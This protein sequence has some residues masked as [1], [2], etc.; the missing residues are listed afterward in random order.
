MNPQELAVLLTP[1]ARGWI[2][3]HRDAQPFALALR[4]APAGLPA[5]LL[6]GQIA[7]LQKAAAKLPSWARNGCIL[8]ARAYEQ[9]TSEALAEAKPWGNGQLALDLSCGLGSDDRALA[10]RFT[11][12]VALEPD[13]L[14]AAVVRDNQG[15]MAIDNVTLL[16]QR[17]EDFVAS[18]DGPQADLIYIDPD[19]RDADG[20]RQ[21][22]LRDCQP[23][24]LALLPRLKAIGK[25][26]LIKASPMLDLQAVEAELAE[27]ATLWVAAEGNECKE[28][29]IEIDTEQPRAARGAI[30]L[31]KG[32]AHQF[33]GQVDAQVQDWPLVEAPAYIFEADTALYKAGLAAAWYGAAENG[34]EGGMAGREGYFFARQD[35]PGFHGHRFKVLATLPFKP[36]DIK[37]YCKAE[38]IAKLQYTRRD[39]DIPLEQVRQQ[40]KMPEGGHL[41]LLLT[42]MGSLGRVALVA[43]RLADS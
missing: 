24:V 41:Y 13:P 21:Y 29:L 38:G 22:G 28:L 30:F 6:I 15:R 37:K 40:V 33:V 31:R 9:A 16:E 8:P 7:L 23:D 11:R 12:V 32:R 36:A 19:R 35:V 42:K 26:I 1:E 2:A 39:F 17:A 34:L 10:G 20:K 4:A 3:A 25:R 27:P 18:Y 43:E 14:L 5:A